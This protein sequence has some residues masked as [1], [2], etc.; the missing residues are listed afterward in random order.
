M[1][2]VNFTS[3]F[4]NFFLRFAVQRDSF[5]TDVFC[6]VRSLVRSFTNWPRYVPVIFIVLKIRYF[7]NN[8]Y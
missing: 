4:Y 8:F 5:I 2:E 1:L 6:S 3:A 7:S